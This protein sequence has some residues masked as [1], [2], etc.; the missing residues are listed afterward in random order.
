MVCVNQ[1]GYV[2][3]TC[4]FLFSKIAKLFQQLGNVAVE[5]VVV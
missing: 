1:G 4:P 5:V 2:V 3:T